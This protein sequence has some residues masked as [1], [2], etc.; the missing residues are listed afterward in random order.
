[1]Y[2][3]LLYST[4]LYSTLSILFYS[5]LLYSLY[6]IQILFSTLYN[7]ILIYF[8]SIFTVP[9]GGYGE[10]EDCINAE[11]EEYRAVL[12]RMEK[13]GTNNNNNNYNHTLII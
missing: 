5:T 13:D 1:M 2:S 6:S 9:E 8:I 10:E 12:E 11:D 7:S 4:L 3:T